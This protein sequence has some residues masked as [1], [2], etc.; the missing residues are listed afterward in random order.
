VSVGGRD[1]NKPDYGL[2]GRCGLGWF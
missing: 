1:L 2:V